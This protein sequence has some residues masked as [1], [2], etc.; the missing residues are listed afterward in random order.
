[1]NRVYEERVVIGIGLWWPVEKPRGCE[2]CRLDLFPNHGHRLEDGTIT[3]EA[4]LR[5]A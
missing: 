2:M 5:W 3:K 4:T 1:M